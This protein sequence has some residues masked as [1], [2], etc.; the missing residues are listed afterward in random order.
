MQYDVEQCRRWNQRHTH[1]PSMYTKVYNIL[2]TPMMV[3]ST[4]GHNCGLRHTAENRKHWGVHVISVGTMPYVEPAPPDR[5]CWQMPVQNCHCCPPTPAPS[6]S[7]SDRE[8]KGLTQ[9]WEAPVGRERTMQYSWRKHIPFPN[10]LTGNRTVWARPQENHSH[11]WRETPVYP[12]ACGFAYC[13]ELAFQSSG[14]M[15]LMGWLVRGTGSALSSSRCSRGTEDRILWR[16]QAP[17]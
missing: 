8:K 16:L 1:S 5:I 6:S 7:Y 11:K 2:G 15:C 17:Q 3:L 10:F 4:K 13:L 9:G 14:E 12:A